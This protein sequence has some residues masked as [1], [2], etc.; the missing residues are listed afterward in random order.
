MYLKLDFCR[1][2]CIACHDIVAIAEGQ[3]MEAHFTLNVI[4]GNQKTEFSLLEF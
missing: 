3:I 4:S 1:T 2:K